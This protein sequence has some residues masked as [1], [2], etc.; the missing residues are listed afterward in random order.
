[1]AVA[2]W[3]CCKDI[4]RNPWCVGSGGL[5]VLV[6]VH[7]MCWWWRVA[8][9]RFSMLA[10]GLLVVGVIHGLGASDGFLVTLLAGK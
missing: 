3:V 5:D 7:W 10:V 6:V 1:M 9:G 2:D 8:G 4:I